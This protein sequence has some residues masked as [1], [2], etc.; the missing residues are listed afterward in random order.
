MKKIWLY[1]HTITFFWVLAGTFSL[2]T[3]RPCFF[4]FPVTKNGY[5]T[6]KNLY[7]PKTHPVFWKDVER[8]KKYPYLVAEDNG[9]I[10]GYAY[11][12]AFH[13][14]PACGWQQKHQYM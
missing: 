12:C 13:E 9:E 7:I 3:H 2:Y 10:V 11:A 8:N 4:L 1:T 5:T 6:A 14:R